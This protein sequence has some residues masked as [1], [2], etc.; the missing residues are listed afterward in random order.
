M[1]DDQLRAKRQ[2]PPAWVEESATPR[3]VNY[4]RVLVEDRVV[5]QMWLDRIGHLTEHKDEFT[6]GKAGEIIAA[7]KPLPKRNPNEPDRAGQ[8]TS[9]SVPSGRYAI[10][11]GPEE[12]DLT[13]YR[14]WW[15][16]R[17][18]AVYQLI[19]PDDI[20]LAKHHARD[21]IKN[22]LRSGPGEAAIRYGQAVGACSKCGRRLTN[23]LSRELA[24]GP[25][26]GQRWFDDWD[27]RVF[28][29]RMDLNKRGI[30]PDEKVEDE[31]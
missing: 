26:C 5:P 12:N 10:Q 7:L 8:V 13:F 14:V 22:V 17:G 2:P 11:T 16:D 30:D 31:V 6:K 29:T 9:D 1:T 19:G 27:L 23:R 4:I 25:V 21:A 3:Q 28:K 24:I 20:Q 15:G 18:Y